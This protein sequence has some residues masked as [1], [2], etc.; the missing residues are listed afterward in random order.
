MAQ[1]AQMKQTS[2]IALL[3]SLWSSALSF[4]NGAY[5]KLPN[6]PI[7]ERSG[8]A[9]LL[10]CI[11]AYAIFV[12]YVFFATPQISVDISTVAGPLAKNSALA[13]MPGESYAYEIPVQGTAMRL[14]YR[15]SSSPLCSGAVVEETYANDRM[16]LCILPNGTLQDEGKDDFDNRSIHLF[17]PWMLAA[18]DDFEWKVE[19]VSRAQ[20][21]E[22]RSAAYFSGAGGAKAGGRDAYR[23]EL[24]MGSENSTPLGTLFVDKEK[25][26]LLSAEG[27]GQTIRLVEAPFALNWSAQD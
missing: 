15:V 17:S 26:I 6:Y 27:N 8:V 21:F 23:I 22:M 16:E 10:F 18:S 2:E 13:V 19:T 1:A 14:R 25:R 12:A 11:A 7:I 24:R 20:G 5:M 4:A 9:L 3:S